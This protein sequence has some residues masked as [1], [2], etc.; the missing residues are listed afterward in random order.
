MAIPIG[1]EGHIKNSERP[2]HVV[3]VRDDTANTGGFLIFESWAGSKGL[4]Q[5]GAFD[6]WVESNTA[7]EQF[8]T[9]SGWVV[10]WKP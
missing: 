2:F 8:F 6:N 7:L 5:N 1:I 9:E 10:Q 4:N 3:L